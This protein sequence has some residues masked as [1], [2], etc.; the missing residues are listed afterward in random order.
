MRKST[1]RSASD[2]I[3]QVLQRHG[4]SVVPDGSGWLT[5]S[6]RDSV[7]KETKLEAIIAGCQ[8]VVRNR[9]HQLSLY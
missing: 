8:F 6:K 3:Q 9:P 7:K 1:H 2:R 4:H 5:M